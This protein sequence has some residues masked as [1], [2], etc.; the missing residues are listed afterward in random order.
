MAV[1][2]E[3]LIGHRRHDHSNNKRREHMSPMQTRTT[4]GQSR[5]GLYSLT[6]PTMIMALQRQAWACMGG[7]FILSRSLTN[8]GE[9]NTV[10]WTLTALASTSTRC[11]GDINVTETLADR[12]ASRSDSVGR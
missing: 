9:K 12:A 11:K 1:G 6:S 2:K 7:R 8:G 3:A 4:L 10:F 5:R